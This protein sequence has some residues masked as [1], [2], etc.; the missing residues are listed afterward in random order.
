MLPAGDLIFLRSF[1]SRFFCR[2]AGDLNHPEEW[3]EDPEKMVSRYISFSLLAFLL[4]F[5]LV[6]CVCVS[7]AALDPERILSRRSL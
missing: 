5:L 3:E 4:L 7:F 6:V 1:L 2:P